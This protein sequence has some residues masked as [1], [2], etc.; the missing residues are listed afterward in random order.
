MSAAPSPTAPATLHK[1]ARA[2]D[3]GLDLAQGADEAVFGW[4][5]ASYLFGKRISQG[6]A[7]RTW[8]VIYH[9]HG[10]TSVAKLQRCTRASLVR[11]LNEGHYSRYDESTA[12]R[13]QEVCAVLQASCQGSLRYLAAR[14]DSREAFE[15]HLLA[16]KGVGPKTLEIFMSEAGPVLFAEHP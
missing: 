11:M 3:L 16:L 7:A 9:K 1:P 13:L 5:L 14:C 6:I 10:C 12:T 2:T 8:E 4:F 15:K